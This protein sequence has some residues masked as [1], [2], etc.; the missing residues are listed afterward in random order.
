MFACVFQGRS[1][2]NV[3]NDERSNESSSD[4]ELR[5]PRA[6]RKGRPSN[7]MLWAEPD[8]ND[9]IPWSTMKGWTSVPGSTQQVIS[10]TFIFV[11]LQGFNSLL[12]L[13]PL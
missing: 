5:P 11:S 10:G 1:D 8:G 3:N 9:D 2:E 4:E 6:K 7:Y 12:I 13:F